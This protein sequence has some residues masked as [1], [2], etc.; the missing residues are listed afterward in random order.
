MT[1]LNPRPVAALLLLAPALSAAEPGRVNF[2]RDVRPILSDKCFRCHGPDAKERRGEL[3]LD[4]REHALKPAQSG[5]AAI[6]PRDGGKSELVRRIL[7][8]D[9]TEVM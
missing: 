7:S 3:R 4:V 5:Q 9:R 6:V 1:A 8:T 2:T